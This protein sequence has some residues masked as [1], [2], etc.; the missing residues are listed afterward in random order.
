MLFWSVSDIA[1]G[2]GGA[3]PSGFTPVNPA[4]VSSLVDG[5]NL[6][7][8]YRVATSAEP[9]SYTISVGN[10]VAGIVSLW[11][12]RLAGFQSSARVVNVG[13]ASPWNLP[14]TGVMLR[15]P[16]DL[17]WFGMSDITTSQSGVS[18]TA[19]MGF[20]KV[21][22]VTLGFYQLL[23]A[24]QENVLPGP[25]PML[26]GIGTFTGRTA[27][28]VVR[29]LALPRANA[30]ARIPLLTRAGISSAIA[31]ISSGFHLRNINR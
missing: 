14:G 6:R 16:S 22:T 28:S 30:N 25:T 4:V 5:G 9:A 3:V 7:L 26:V 18:Y 24:M 2:G 8:S 19:P 31:A 1:G 12:V 15:E 20:S 11:G 27:G 29:V 21:R 10:T 23:V 17:L 13:R